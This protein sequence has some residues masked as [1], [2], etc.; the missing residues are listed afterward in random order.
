MKRPEYTS[1]RRG[2]ATRLLAIGEEIRISTLGEIESLLRAGDLLVVN[3]SGTMPASLPVV[4]ERTGASF[5]VRLAVREGDS[6]RWLAVAFGSGT[7]RDRT[8]D[9]GAPPALH[10]GDLLRIGPELRAFVRR[11]DGRH[12]RLVHL[13]FEG[14]LSAL[15]RVGRP[16]QYSY[17]RDSLTLWDSQT[18]VA[19]ACWSVEAPSSLFPLTASRLVALKRR[20]RVVSLMHGAGLSSTGDIALDA[21]L[22]L[23]EPYRIPDSTLEAVRET[24][25]Q[26]GRV[27]AWGTSVARALESVAAGEPPSGIATLKLGRGRPLLIVD[28]LVT[29]FHEP[30]TS[31]YGLEEAFVAPAKLERAFRAGRG[32]GLLGHEYGDLALLWKESV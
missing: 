23:P 2:D 9:R 6:S 16:V 21:L 3:E 30:G 13:R 11:L 4:L 18:P 15:Y 8:E 26:G 22:P 1:R 20:H 14:D 5:E 25:R 7:W 28:G 12:G 19:A 29:G 32:A 17:H 24:K 10:A 27:V 31:H